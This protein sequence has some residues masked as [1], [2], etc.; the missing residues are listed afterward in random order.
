MSDIPEDRIVYVALGNLMPASSESQLEYYDEENGKAIYIFRP[1]Y[2]S[3]TFQLQTAHFDGEL[4]MDLSA[5]KFKP[6][7]VSSRRDLFHFDGSF[8]KGFLSG[9][10]DRVSYT[11]YVPY[12][13]EGMVIEIEMKG[14]K[15]DEGALPDDWENWRYLNN[16]IYAVQYKPTGLLNQVT[17]NLV[18]DIPDIQESCSVTVQSKGYETETNSISAAQIIPAGNLRTTTDVREYDLYLYSTDPGTSQNVTPLAEI[19][20]ITSYGSWGNIV[21]YNK[22]DIQVSGVS[23]D[24]TIYVRYKIDNNYFDMYS[25]ASFKLSDAV[26][27]QVTLNFE[28][29]W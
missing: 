26:N 8:S 16:D 22:N 6:A 17:I 11:F 1:E 12:Y 4:S 14:L 10:A 19:T 9:V 21:Y 28:Y 13:Y 25:I 27:G 7:S 23:P 2:I 3:G 24:S 5:Y 18:T 15:F 20:E 29:V